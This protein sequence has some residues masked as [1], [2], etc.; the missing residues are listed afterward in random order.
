MVFV[1]KS[2]KKTFKRKYRKYQK[3]QFKSMSKV[4]RSLTYNNQL[5]SFK[6]K[7]LLSTIPMAT[8]TSGVSSHPYMFSH[9]TIFSSMPNAT[10]YS[11]L[12]K[13]Y[14]IN[15]VKLEIQFPF[16]IT[17]DG[18]SSSLAVHSAIDYTSSLTPVSNID[19]IQEYGT[20]KKWCPQA[21]NRI[22]KRFFKPRTGHLVTTNVAGVDGTQAQTP[23]W[24]DFDQP[25]GQDIM[26]Q[27]MQIGI[28]YDGPVAGGG[29]IWVYQTLYFQCKY[30]R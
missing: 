4:S 18:V 24:C 1:K 27:G 25:N 15:G 17:Y 6:R 22:F 23:G 9:Y 30:T 29:Q 11:S 16:D 14:K 5:H 13:L 19:V 20:Y 2:Y 10:E 8:I 28:S 12:F 21:G 26:H 3:K 7:Y